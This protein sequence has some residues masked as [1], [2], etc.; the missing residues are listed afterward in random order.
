MQI[1]HILQSNNSLMLII[2]GDMDAQGCSDM[3]PE[4]DDVVATDEL[5][6]IILNLG[7]VDFLDSSGIGAIVFLFKRLKTKGRT[8]SLI[9]VHGQPMEIIQLLRI[10]SAI[11]VEMSSPVR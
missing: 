2:Y 3:Q 7:Y 6:D 5:T 10:N 9:Q 11:S 4:L 1:E 8:L